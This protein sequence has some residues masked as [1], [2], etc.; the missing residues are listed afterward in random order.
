MT[1]P[2][3]KNSTFLE[4]QKKYVPVPESNSHLPTSGELEQPCV[5][6]IISTT[7]TTITTTAAPIMMIKFLVLVLIPVLA[8]APYGE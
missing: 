6:T 5:R 4:V 3:D 8:G 7:A 1:V 2:F